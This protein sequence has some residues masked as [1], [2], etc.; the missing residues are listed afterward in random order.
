MK[1]L[2]ERCTVSSGGEA[3]RASKFQHAAGRLTEEQWHELMRSLID[4]ED[5]PID[6]EAENLKLQEVASRDHASK[7][8]MNRQ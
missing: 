6:D 4:D 3:M 8:R 7:V 2:L 1:H 5:R